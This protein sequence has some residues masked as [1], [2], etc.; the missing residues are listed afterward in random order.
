MAKSFI[1]NLN[2]IKK[3]SIQT[4]T[5]RSEDWLKNKLLRQDFDSKYLTARPEIGNMYQFVYKPKLRDVLPYWDRNPLII[6]INKTSS[7]FTG[8]NLHYLSPKFRAI[9]LDNLMVFATDVNMTD[10]TKLILSW[11]LLRSV[12]K[13]KLAR[14]TVKRYLY[15]NVV[16]KFA[17]IPAE[18]WENAIFLPTARFV[19]KSNNEVYTESRRVL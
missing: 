9:L 10:E 1:D 2:E 18:D 3:E 6:L 15:S 14:P 4:S 19:G 5:R 7:F 17:F 13:Y 12:A 11:R 8:L 16:T